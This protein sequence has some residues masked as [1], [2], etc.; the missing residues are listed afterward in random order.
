MPVR[1]ALSRGFGWLAARTTDERLVVLLAVAVSV[2]AYAWYASRGLTFGYADALSRMEIARRVLISRTP[3][4]AQLGTT[5]L[6]L[7]P[8]LMLPLI[9]NNT[10]F[11]DG[12][13]GSFPSMVAYVIASLYMYRMIRFLFSKR[14]AAWVAAVAFIINPSVVYMQATAMSEVP[15]ICTAVVA[16]YYMLVWVRSYH[17]ADLMKSA[18][19]V[20]AGTAIRYDGWPLAVAF[21]V[22]VVYLAWRHRGSQ[23]ALAW[24]IAYGM[25]AFSGCAAWVIYNQVI[26]H[27][28]I[29][30]V[31]FGNSKNTINLAAL[32]A[33]HNAK[34]AFEMYGY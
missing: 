29:L 22:V 21:A 1:A 14:G 12:F 17:A 30:F 26:F 31:F 32:P 8:M 34:L 28:P 4:L 9:W 19:A 16:I 13:A 33:Y 18:A 3:G 15:M 5:W 7:Q 11:H 10:L 27:D 2:G 20:A 23:G 25:L 24:L 6:P